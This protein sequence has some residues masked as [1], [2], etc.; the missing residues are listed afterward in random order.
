MRAE[1]WNTLWT[2]E[3]NESRLAFH[4]SLEETTA[5][6]KKETPNANI[7]LLDLD[8]VDLDSV[9]KAAREVNGYSEPINVL[10]NNAAT[11]VS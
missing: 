6:I 9:R 2:E 5:A 3:P 10:I 1:R 7:R 8:L 11:M 4:Y